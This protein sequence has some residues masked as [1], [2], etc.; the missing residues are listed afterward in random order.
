MRR[1]KNITIVVTSLIMSAILLTA[2]VAVNSY[3]PVGHLLPNY[4]LLPQQDKTQIEC[5]AE[6]IL[7][8]AGSE[9][10]EGQVAVAMVT[11]NRVNAGG[12]FGKSVCGVVQQRTHLT[13]QFSWWC[14][15]HLQ[16]KAVNNKYDL[17]Q[18]KKVK[19]V[20]MLVYM[21]YEVMK[22]NTHGSLFYHAVYVSP[23]WQGL[24][25]TVQIGQHIF[26]KHK[27]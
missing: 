11:M 26:Y 6:N 12:V 17:E 22:D 16:Y 14:N 21:N 7:F 19:E 2:A 20:A 18:Y 1:I 23:N 24:Q 13:C 4:N 9:P 15:P 25:K 10:R 5:L 8:E 3:N 27:I